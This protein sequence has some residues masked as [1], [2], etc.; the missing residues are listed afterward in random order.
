MNMQVSVFEI[1]LGTLGTHASGVLFL[2]RQRSLQRRQER[3]VYV[4]IDRVPE[5]IRLARSFRFNA[6]CQVWSI[7]ASHRTFA[8]AAQQI[9]Q[10]FVT[11]KVQTFLGHFEL[12]VARQRLFDAAFAI[13]SNL[14]SLFCGWFLAKV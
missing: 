10:C 11:E 13:S 3:R 8:Q 1:Y 6:R 7:V 14:A 9:P 5:L 12:D 4:K 2:F